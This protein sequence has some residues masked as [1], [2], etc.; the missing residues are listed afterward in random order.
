MK[1]GDKV[2]W[3]STS[4]GRTT[5]K[6][7]AIAAVIPPNTKPDN[8]VAAAKAATGASF[9]STAGFGMARDHQ[10]YLV[11]VPTKTGRGNGKLYWPRVSNLCLFNDG[12]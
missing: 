3:V 11:H 4:N 2:T 7:G 9:S 6:Y 12:I 5:R 1:V 8:F 10:S